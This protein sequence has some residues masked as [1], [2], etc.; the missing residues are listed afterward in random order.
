MKITK[1]LAFSFVLLSTGLMGCQS[2]TI[3]NSAQMNR[4]TQMN[5]MAQVAESRIPVGERTILSVRNIRNENRLVI[6]LNAHKLGF[7][8]QISI[9]YTPYPY[10]KLLNVD[11]VIQPYDAY[12]NQRYTIQANEQER[13]SVLQNA[14]KSYP[15]D[16]TGPN[17]YESKE[18]L[19][20]AIRLIDGQTAQF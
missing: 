8:E 18:L 15:M 10:V 9:L 12:Q 2:Q 20:L 14:L 3:N 19:E 1:I 5:Q 13:L 7:D 17:P 6:Y 16:N 11:G 4:M